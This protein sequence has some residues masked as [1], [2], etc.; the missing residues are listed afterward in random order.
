MLAFAVAC[1]LLGC[2]IAPYD[3]DDYLPERNYGELRGDQRLHRDPIPYRD[4]GD[5][6]RGLNDR[7]RD[8]GHHDQWR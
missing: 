5:Y 8:A 3:D 2:T 6:H 1:T 7:D 4:D